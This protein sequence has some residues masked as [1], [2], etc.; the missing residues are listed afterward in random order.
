[1]FVGGVFLAGRYLCFGGKIFVFLEWPL[2]CACCEWG[3]VC[4]V[5]VSVCLVCV[6]CE[7][8]F[9]LCV[10]VWVCVSR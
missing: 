10:S 1:M 4:V 2:V 6:V 3:V 7:C 9:M 5:C 8:V